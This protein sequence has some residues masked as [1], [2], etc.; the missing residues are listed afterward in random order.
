M[1]S[2]P[3]KHIGIFIIHDDIC[4]FALLLK[5]ILINENTFTVLCKYFGTYLVL[6]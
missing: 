6:K 5:L 3:R 4:Y 2:F 1:Q